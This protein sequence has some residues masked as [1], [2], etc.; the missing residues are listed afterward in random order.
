MAGAVTIGNVEVRHFNDVVWDFPIT[1]DQLFPAV[2]AEAWEP[3]RQRYPAAFAGPNVWRSPCCSLLIKSQGQT[4]LL[5]TG[6]GPATRAIAAWLNASGQLM[7][8]LGRANVRPEDVDTVLLTHLH[9]D[10]VGWNL[11]GEGSERRLTFPRARYLAHQADWETFNKPEVQQAIPWPYVGDTITPLQEMGALDLLI[12]DRVITSELTAIHTPGHTPGS[13]S[14]LVVSG[15][16]RALLCGDLFAHPAQ[17]TDP[18]MGFAFDFDGVL[19]AQTRHSLL[20]RIEAEGMTLSACH[21]PEPGFGSVIRL[22]G[23]RYWQAM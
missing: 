1:L 7:E 12:A 14:L 9:P 20:E 5:D 10:H 18:D 11:Q 19:A 6:I 15:G 4:L 3:Y 8:E 22:E 23:R 21:F 16:Q 17:V 2:T 13:I